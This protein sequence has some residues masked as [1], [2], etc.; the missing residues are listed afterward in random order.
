MGYSTLT[1][2]RA[3]LDAAPKI[4]VRKEGF[5]FGGTIT[6]SSI[7]DLFSISGGYPTNG[8]EA[9]TLAG[10]TYSKT[11]AGAIPLGTATVGSSLYGL[12]DV[13]ASA[14]WSPTNPSGTAQNPGMDYYIH[15][16]DRVWANADI[17]PTLT[18]RQSWSPPALPRYTTGEGLSLWCRYLVGGFSP[19]DVVMTIEYVN[20]AGV[21]RTHP[22]PAYL[23]SNA[24]QN[25]PIIW[26]M[27]LVTGDTGIRSINAVTMGVS[28]PV[29]SGRYSFMI[30]KYLGCY[31]IGS[32][33]Y[34]V[35][36]A[37]R[38][39]MTGIPTF[40]GNACLQTGVQV[41]GPFNVG[42][43]GVFP[44]LAFEAKVLAL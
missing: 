13:Q 34:S 2:L 11:S 35:N 22:V 3:A 8:V 25:W 15:V 28:M 20:Q 23:A 5:A 21:S 43:G 44:T 16:W 17:N 37:P 14:Y 4:S 6:F 41:G 12:A 30:A 40:D 38:S 42:N 7:W 36:S 32:P 26:Q 9:T 18:S 33:S 31:R 27:P 10:L 24:M 39:I 29:T 1:S 19:P